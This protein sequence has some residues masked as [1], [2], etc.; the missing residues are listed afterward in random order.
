MNRLN[1]LLLAVPM[2]CLTGSS[3]LFAQE[4]AKPDTVR[5]DTVAVP[6]TTAEAAVDSA[7]PVI[8]FGAYVDTYFAWDFGQPDAFD[9]PFTTQP[10]RHDEFN[11]NLAFV[12]A[13]L[14]TE[15]VRGRVALQAGTSVQAN[16]L[17]EPRVGVVSGPDVSRI[18]QEA[19][20]GVRVARGLWI[21]GGI[22]FSP[23]GWESWISWDNPTYTRSLL[24]DYTPYFVTGVRAVWTVSPKV[25]AQAQVVNG[26]QIVSENN[27]DKS[28]I[29]RIDWQATKALTLAY[30]TYAGNEQLDSLPSRTRFY[31]QVLAKVV[32]GHGWEFW[33][34]FDVGVQT[35]PDASSQAWYGAVVIARKALSTSL[36]V[37]G[38]LEGHS[39]RDQVL[40]ITG[41][42]DGFRTIGGS[43]GV[44]VQPAEYLKWRTELRGF[45]SS[46]PIWP[47]DGA[48][49]GSES[50]GFVVTS[51]SLRF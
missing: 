3:A 46:D 32:A 5:V 43:I 16:Y 6:A 2:A 37:V 30:A 24:A 23:I 21:D 9:R 42:P 33:G 7:K 4:V 15:K 29:A 51:L 25:T 35:V 19:W 39:D 31:N 13:K 34:T 12:E 1:L 44:D 18:I 27:P 20:A 10:A 11:V 47:S 36:A 40:I 50:G 38:R 22:Y 28:V 26:W 45:S 14:T 41:T 17:G 48:P 49:A 8:A